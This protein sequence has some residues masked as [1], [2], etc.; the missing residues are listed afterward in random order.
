[1]LAQLNILCRGS[2]S[3]SIILTWSL[4]RNKLRLPITAA[5][6]GPSPDQD[7]H[8]NVDEDAEPEHAGNDAE[9]KKILGLVFAW[10]EICAVNLGKITHGI[11]QGNGDSADFWRH[12]RE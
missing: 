5:Q 12:G 10:E 3:Y 7:V 6:R 4:S 8:D 1:M 2:Q 9:S 11:D